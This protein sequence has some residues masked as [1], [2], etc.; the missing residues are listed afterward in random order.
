MMEQPSESMVIN[1]FQT[2]EDFAKLRDFLYEKTGLFFPD[3]K[4]YFLEPRFARRMAALNLSTFD[5]YHAYLRFKDSSKQEL[6]QLV[7]EVTIQETSFFRN[8]PQMDGLQRVIVPELIKDRSRSIVSK[9]S[10]W[11]AAC[12]T[13]EEPYSLAMIA[14]EHSKKELSGWNVRILAT[15]IST[16]ALM[17]AQK[18]EYTQY[19]VRNMPKY[20]MQK[21]LKPATDKFIIDPGIQKMVE[22]RQVNLSDDMTMVFLKGFDIIFCRNV[23]IYF[24]TKSKQKVIQHFYNNLNKGGYLFLGFSESLFGIDDR[25][26]TVHFAGGMAY[27]KPF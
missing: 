14:A 24:D 12:S 10:I 23:L 25:F 20:F 8:M 9:L 1:G 11:S 17:T 13:G 19:S 3:G 18:G 5:Q 2:Q 26:K 16:R 15:D 6:H 22:F 21:Y 7:N 27:Q 4:K